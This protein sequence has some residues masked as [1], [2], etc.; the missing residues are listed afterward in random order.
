MTH[1]SITK[2]E[3]EEAGIKDSLIRVSIGVEDKVDLTH[4]LEQAFNQI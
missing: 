4:D 2:K 3:R 1:S